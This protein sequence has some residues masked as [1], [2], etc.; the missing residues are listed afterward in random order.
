MEDISGE[1]TGIRRK[2]HMHPELG[3]REY[4]TAKYI[5][6]YLKNLGFEVIEDVAKTGVIGILRGSE[7]RR[8][9]AV[10]SEMDCLQVTEHTGAEY[11]SKIPGLM[12]ACGHDGHMAILLGLAKEYSKSKKH[13]KDN[14]IFIFQPAEEG[15]G[16]AAKIVEAKVLD[17]FNVRAFIATHIFPELEQG[18]FGCCSGPLTARNGEVDIHVAGKAAHGAM[19]HKGIDSVVVLS[20]LI[21]AMQT[22]VSRRLDPLESAVVTFGRVSAGEV[23]NVI[24]GSAKIEGTIRA[25][26]EDTYRA[27]KDDISMICSGIGE[28]NGC[29]V[30]ADI[31]DMYREVFNDKKLFQ[32]FLDA[33]GR[34]RVKEIKPLMIAEDFSFYS[35]IAPELMFMAGSRNEKEGYIY[36]LHN[37]QFNFDEQILPECAS[38]IDRMITMIEQ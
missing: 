4:D 27:I 36:P 25:F 20:Q 3:F 6:G 14:I 30:D 1:I 22:I 19:P 28:A 31:T 11:S 38:I 34:D 32:I 5:A 18:T 16:G 24:A 15:P 37:A 17:G 10:R 23:R 7:G 8:S 29:E 21:Q 26:S 13:F 12:H 2:L 35:S 9:V 33:A